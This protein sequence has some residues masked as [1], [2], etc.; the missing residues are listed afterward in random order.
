M[1]QHMEA[2]KSRRMDALQRRVAD[3]LE[4]EGLL[5]RDVNARLRLLVAEL[6]PQN[7]ETS[8]M[9]V[10]NEEPGVVARGAATLSVISVW[11]PTEELCAVLGKVRVCVRVTCFL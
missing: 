10:G 3:A 4:E 11:G 1:R 2:K 9:E 5:Q 6:P 7:R 8:P